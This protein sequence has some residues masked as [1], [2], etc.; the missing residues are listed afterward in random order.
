[1]YN[2]YININNNNNNTY[3]KHRILVECSSALYIK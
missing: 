1:M 2:K 3:M